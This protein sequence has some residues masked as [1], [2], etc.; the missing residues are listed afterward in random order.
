MKSLSGGVETV[1]YRRASKAEI[2]SKL[3]GKCQQIPL[4]RK[5]KRILLRQECSS[6]PVGFNQEK[7]EGDKKQ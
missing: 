1:T 2:Q 6:L 5:K 3:K 7:M 4:E